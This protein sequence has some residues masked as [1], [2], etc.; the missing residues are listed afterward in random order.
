LI[1]ALLPLH[2][3]GK[4]S[5]TQPVGSNE[6]AGFF[7]PFV[8]NYLNLKL[9]KRRGTMHPAHLPLGP[10]VA[11][12]SGILILVMPRLL[13]YVIALYLIIEGILGLTRGYW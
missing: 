6:P 4:S 1:S 12:I 5:Q 3:E 7:C 2:R 13:N 11:L 10:V 9:L 8:L